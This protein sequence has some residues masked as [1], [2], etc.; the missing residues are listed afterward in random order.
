LPK[1]RKYQ[2]S[3]NTPGTQEE[4]PSTGGSAR[5]KTSFVCEI[6][7]EQLK[8]SNSP[9]ETKG[10][11]KGKKAPK[12]NKEDVKTKQQE[13][14]EAPRNTKTKGKVRTTTA[15]GS[16]ET[17]TDAKRKLRASNANQNAQ[18]KAQDN[19]G[20]SKSRSKGADWIQAH[21]VDWLSSS[22]VSNAL[23]VNRP[24]LDLEGRDYE[25]IVDLLLLK[26]T[27]SKILR[28]SADLQKKFIL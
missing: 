20:D 5:S 11:A 10:Q 28:S 15:K 12:K 8:F 14:E 16:K 18:P 6:F 24:E 19:D 27:P 22:G 9:A 1:A 3:K 13:K 23:S 26:L 4:T 21:Q 17:A 7:G 25:E 2:Q